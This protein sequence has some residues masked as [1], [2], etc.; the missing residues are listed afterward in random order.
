MKLNGYI[1]SGYVNR[2]GE[3][4]VLDPEAFPS[5]EEYETIL[6]VMHTDYVFSFTKAGVVA[7]PNVE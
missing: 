2:N 3:Q 4:L 1:A 6:Q 7:V 5:E